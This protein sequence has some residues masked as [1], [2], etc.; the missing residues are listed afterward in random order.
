MAWHYC[1]GYYASLRSWLWIVLGALLDTFRD[2][3][4]VRK[5]ICTVGWTSINA[6]GTVIWT[7]ILYHANSIVPTVC[8]P[9]CHFHVGL[10]FC[11]A[12]HACHHPL[13][14][15]RWKATL[16]IVVMVSG[17]CIVRWMSCGWHVWK[18]KNMGNSVMPLITSPGHASSG[19]DD[20]IFPCKVMDVYFKCW[21]EHIIF[22][23]HYCDYNVVPVHLGFMFIW[24]V[25][26]LQVWSCMPPMHAMFALFAV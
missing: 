3:P 24:H 19:L 26:V 14:C 16:Q 8:E 13:C 20:T 11:I 12:S 2:A 25:K 7:G 10:W 23:N 17:P 18:T 9:L 1:V 21:T 15:P 6:L 22:Y 4:L 5:I